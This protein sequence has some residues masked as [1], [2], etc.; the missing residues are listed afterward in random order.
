V[1]EETSISKDSERSRLARAK[2]ALQ[3]ARLLLGEPTQRRASLEA[4]SSLGELLAALERVRAELHEDDAES[5]LSLLNQA[6]RLLQLKAG[7]GLARRD[8]RLLRLLLAQLERALFGASPLMR[9]LLLGLLQLSLLALAL[10]AGLVLAKQPTQGVLASYYSKP[11]FQGERL[12]FIEARVRHR[13]GTGAPAPS[14]PADNFSARYQSCLRLEEAAELRFRVGSDD[15]TRLRVDGELLI[16]AW[17]RQ[18]FHWEEAL[19]PLSAGRHLIELEYFEAGDKAAVAMEVSLAAAGAAPL[20]DR[21]FELPSPEATCP[22]G[23]LY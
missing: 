8:R 7:E 10:G 2:S 12:Q 5:A 6:T 13:F 22:S 21:F 19:L 17:R 9:P 14:M 16:D 15:G 23:L 4:Q 1:S 3:S 20:D 18:G 11:D